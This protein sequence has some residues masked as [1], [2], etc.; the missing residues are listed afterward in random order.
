MT[1]RSDPT[2]IASESMPVA[3]DPTAVGSESMPVPWG[4]VRVAQAPIAIDSGRN[5]P[6]DDRNS[7]R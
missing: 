6:R 2:A 1:L 5:R 7:L 3:P 4:L